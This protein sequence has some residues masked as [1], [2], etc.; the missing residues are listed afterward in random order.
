MMMLTMMCMVM[1]L[2]LLLHFVVDLAFVESNTCAFKRWGVMPDMSIMTF[3]MRSD[4]GLCLT[5]PIMTYLMGAY[6]LMVPHAYCI[7]EPVMLHCRVGVV[8]WLVV[9]VVFD[10]VLWCEVM[11]I[12]CDG[13]I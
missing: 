13:C 4:G 3:T 12:I 11:L 1:K 9:V 5:C 2:L 7:F 8:A 6:A 10:V